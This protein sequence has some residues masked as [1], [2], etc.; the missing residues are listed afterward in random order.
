ME[1]ESKIRAIKFLSAE[2]QWYEV[3]NVYRL[4]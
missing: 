3:W 4:M 1:E 2:P